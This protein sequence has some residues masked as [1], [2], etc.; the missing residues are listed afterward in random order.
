[1]EAGSPVG[2]RK[3]SEQEG[4]ERSEPSV[5]FSLLTGTPKELFATSTSPV[6]FL[7]MCNSTAAPARSSPNN[8]RNREMI[9]Q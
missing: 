6:I 4:G 5:P 3:E 9:D 2:G 8:S 1:M 7:T